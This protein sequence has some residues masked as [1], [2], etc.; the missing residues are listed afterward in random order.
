MIGY[1]AQPPNALMS[2]DPPLL[3]RSLSL[4]MPACLPPPTFP[5][6]RTCMPKEPLRYDAAVTRAIATHD[7][8]IYGAHVTPCR[9]ARHPSPTAV[10]Y[11][12]KPNDAAV[13]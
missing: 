9:H 10:N 3:A 4:T 12:L 6:P 5:F 1:A 13:I 11:R 8:T 2:R 7:L